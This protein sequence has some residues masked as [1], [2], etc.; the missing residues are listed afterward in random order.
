MLT[1]FGC[2]AL[3]SWFGWHG[4][5]GPRGLDNYARLEARLAANKEA[6][7]QVTQK[8]EAVEARVSLMR[9]ESVD[10]DMASELVREM[11]GYEKLNSIVV[12]YN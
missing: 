5:E 7:A 4:L 2:C 1:F 11:L 6:L 9:P 12:K 10:P 3:L 8:R